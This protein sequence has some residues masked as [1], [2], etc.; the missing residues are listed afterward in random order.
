VS[1][2]SDPAEVVDPTVAGT[3]SVLRSAAKVPSVKRIVLTSSSTAA[4]FPKENVVFEV[5]ED[6]WND[7]S[8]ELAYSLAADHPL[9]AWHVYSA[10]KTLGERAAWNFVKEHK[11]TFTLNTIIPDTNFG[12]LLD[13]EQA[14]STA[15]WVRQA[16]KG[17]LQ[18][19]KQLPPQWYVDVRDTANLHV[20][21]LTSPLLAAGGTRTWAAA[22]PFNVNDVLRTLR[23]I[24]PERTF[25]ADVEDVG[26]D[27]SR[28]DNKRGGE[29]LGGWRSMKDALRDNTEDLV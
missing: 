1:F 20:A 13:S 2:S 15:G 24:Y 21:A 25:P 12:P 6:L 27:L 4:L 23:E 18:M 29:L 22:G 14:G 7:E 17:D 19:L 5:G 16:F 26:R 8:V 9:K 10:S 3:L 28:I 11:P